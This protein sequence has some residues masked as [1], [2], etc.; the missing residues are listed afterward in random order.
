MVKFINL[1]PHLVNVE[2][3]QDLLASLDAGRGGVWL[4]GD[5]LDPGPL[6]D[7]Q[8]GV[9]VVEP[10]DVA[11]P[12][13]PGGDGPDQI[14]QDDNCSVLQWSSS[15]EASLVESLLRQQSYAIKNQLMYP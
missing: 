11:D 14:K 5:V 13:Q 7:H 10:G 4:T 6:V 12:G 1:R 8:G 9:A 3:L 15:K 2:S